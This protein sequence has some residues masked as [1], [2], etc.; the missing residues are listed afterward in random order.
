MQSR[1]LFTNYAV[2]FWIRP[3]PRTPPH[4][5]PF[6]FLHCRSP[7]GAAPA[8]IW[9]ASV[10]QKVIGQGLAVPSTLS[11]AARRPIAK[12]CR[13]D[14]RR[15]YRGRGL[16]SISRVNNSTRGYST[17]VP[18]LPLRRFFRF[19]D[20]SATTLEATQHLHKITEKIYFTE[21]TVLKITYSIYFSSRTLF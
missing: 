16:K 17:V 20:A 12:R 1:R 3:S 2:Y 13:S 19:R 11:G 7:W 15:S 9:A 10:V 5:A 4:T 14:A 6:P 18:L 8:T 21:R